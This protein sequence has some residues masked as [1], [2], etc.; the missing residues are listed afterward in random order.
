M[1]D[2]VV[3]VRR[4]SF[5]VVAVALAAGCGGAKSYAAKADAI[6]KKY[7]KQ[8][9]ALGRPK[10][11]AGLVAVADKT[12]PIVDRAAR[13]LA[14]LEPPPDKRATAAQWLA[15]FRTLRADLREIRDKARAGDSK[16]LTAVA[17]RAQQDNAKANELG[18]RLGF[19]V[20]NKN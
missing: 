10:D 17:L 19:K 12:L 2:T 16:G 1:R 8:T 14:A 6:C 7:T 15:Q 9:S 18:T 13:E 11:L 20:C 3:S 5:L 4:A